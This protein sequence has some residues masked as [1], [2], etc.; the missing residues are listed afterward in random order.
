M[1]IGEKLTFLELKKTGST[2]TQQI[3]NAL[4]CCS[5]YIKGKHNRIYNFELPERNELLVKKVVGGI[6]NPW[7]WYVSLWAFGCEGQGLLYNYF[8]KVARDNQ[9]KTLNETSRRDWQCVLAEKT[10]QNFR[11]WLHRL[12]VSHREDLPEGFNRNQFFR[13]CGY[14]T[15]CYFRLYTLDDHPHLGLIMNHQASHD[16]DQKNNFINQFLRIEHL[17]EDL[18]EALEHLPLTESD[19]QL[20]TRLSRQPV[21]QSGRHQDYRHYYDTASAELVASQDRYVIHKHGYS[22]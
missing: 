8:V 17:T 14:L 19:K 2:R 15:F 11:A 21:N 3:L 12:L 1:F 4:P 10:P 16:Y 18:F 22:F 9:R 6:R 7:D 20:V 5:G 13:F